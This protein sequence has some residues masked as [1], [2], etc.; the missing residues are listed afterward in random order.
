MGCVPGAGVLGL[1]T[2]VVVRNKDVTPW[3]TAEVLCSD[4]D[5]VPPSFINVKTNG[6]DGGNSTINSKL[7]PFKL[8]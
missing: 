2:R 4:F 3:L 6:K 8:C 5:M 7:C 1:R